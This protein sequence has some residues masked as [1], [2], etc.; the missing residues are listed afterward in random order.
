MSVSRW[1]EGWAGGEAAARAND[2][3]RRILTAALEERRAG[4]ADA[5]ALLS[6]LPAPTAAQG[7]DVGGT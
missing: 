6:P 1:L 7:E 5:G 4:C 2:A 3:A